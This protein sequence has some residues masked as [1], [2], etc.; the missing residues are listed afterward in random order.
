MKKNLIVSGLIATTM[1]V[2]HFS[3]ASPT[4][5]AG[6]G[7]DDL[8]PWTAQD[9]LRSVTGFITSI[10]NLCG[11]GES[12]AQL[13]ATQEENDKNTSGASGSVDGTDT[14]SGSLTDT[15]GSAGASEFSGSAFEYV[16]ANILAKEGNVGYKPLKEALSSAT[17]SDTLRSNIRKSVLEEFFADTTKEEQKTT[18]YQNKIRQQRSAYVQEAAGRHVT[19]GYRVKNNIQNDLSVISSVP[20]AGD[21]ELGAIAV[22]SHTLEQMVKMELVDLALQIEMMEADAIQFLMHQPVVLMS[23]T[24]PTSND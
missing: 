7:G 9:F 24:K 19:L 23:E 20:L 16:N 21:G 6:T 17:E 5:F 22:D 18:E 10:V 12:K 3:Y 8:A 1:M 14:S 13:I 2:S 15:L 4:D 11:E